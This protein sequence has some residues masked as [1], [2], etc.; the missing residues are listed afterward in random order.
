MDYQTKL[1]KFISS[2]YLYAGV[3]ITAS[4]IIPAVL[5][6][7]QGLMAEMMAI[8]LGALFVSLTDNAGPLQYRRNGMLA[9]IALNFVV[10]VITGFSRN[11]PWL[12]GIEIIIFSLLFSLIGIFGGRSNAIGSIALVVFILNID[13]TNAHDNPWMHGLYLTIGGVW[14]LI[15]NFLLYR[16]RPYKII[17]QLLGECLMET[18][19]YLRLKAKFYSNIELYD[20][21]NADL[22]QHQV[23][24]QTQH[25]ELREMLFATRQFTEET[26]NKGRSLMMMFLDSIDLLERIMTAQQNYKQLHERFDEERI[27][28]R[29]HDNI[30]VLANTLHNIGL[31]VQSGYSYSAVADLDHSFEETMKTF[32]DL[33]EEKMNAKNIEQFITVRHIIYSLQDITER[34]KRLIA[35]ST[36]NNKFKKNIEGYKREQQLVAHE[37]VSFSLIKSNLSLESAHFKH[38]VR[39][40]VALLAGYILSLLFPL[41]HGYWILLT[42]STIIKPAYSITRTRNAQR[43]AG[44]FIGAAGGFLV[45]YFLPQGNAL[46]V[47]LVISMIAAYSF[48]RLQYL[49]STAMITVY[50]LISFHFLSP[51]GLTTVLGDRII[52]TTI[53][54]VIAFIVSYFVLP[55]WEST[56]ISALA[57]KAV[58]TNREY[59]LAV[60]GAFTANSVNVQTLAATRKEAFVALA[61]L[62]DNFQRMLSEPKNQQLNVKQY[63]QFVSASHM[64]T[65]HIASL[66]YYAQRYGTKYANE[67]FLPMVKQIDRQFKKTAE[68]LEG[69]LKELQLTTQFPIHRKVQQLMEQRKKDLEAGV[70]S[71]MET[72]RR[73][74]SDLKTII[75]QFQLIHGVIVDE[76]KIVSRIKQVQ[77]SAA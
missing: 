3:R 39:L 22:L 45:L 2:Q 9:A 66:S 42:I 16:L 28:N 1:R 58:K 30:V 67:D 34:I 68:L 52:D 14:S 62:S 23:K 12:I 41:G 31:A 7:K 72:V 53:G 36:Y 71:D 61:N 77:L 25:A 33:R 50:V 24:I 37:S 60:A 32:V 10:A 21:L 35:Y 6:Y 75:D 65:S 64:L 26:T 13:A 18:A 47:I 59:F 70:E 17:Q 54:S 40:T 69:E 11:Y 43:L 20:Q 19:E 4:F 57:S 49:V 5:L 15:L 56:Q 63:H 44:T 76:L 27:L 73:T 51:I 29:I 8:P 55:T 74:L 48:L 38:A 46:F